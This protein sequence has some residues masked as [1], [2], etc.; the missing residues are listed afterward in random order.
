MPPLLL[1]PPPP[2]PGVTHEA[3]EV[4]VLLEGAYYTRLPSMFGRAQKRIDV[5]M[6]HIAMPS[7]SHPTRKL[8][9]ALIRASDRGIRVRVLVDAD[10]PKDPYRSTIINAAAVEYLSGGGV[11]V[12]SD[13]P[14]RLLHSK[15]VLI[16]NEW[17]VIGSHNWSAGSY[18][19]FDDLTLAIRSESA[20]REQRR[21]FNM[22]W[23]AARTRE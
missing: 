5:C 15:F 16:D 12:R 6:F 22:M 18:F 13:L 11:A 23:T 4:I 19:Q 10:R 1:Q 17:A 7:R 9:N 2:K 3:A 21:R 20:V 14:E 8:L